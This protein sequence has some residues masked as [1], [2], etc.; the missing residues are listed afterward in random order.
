MIL[1]NHE[2]KIVCSHRSSIIKKNQSCSFCSALL[3]AGTQV[4]SFGVL[5]PFNRQWERLYFC[6]DHSNIMENMNPEDL[7]VFHQEYLV[8]QGFINEIYGN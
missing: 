6:N 1:E 3:S 2:L 5:D 8:H 4:N 7:P